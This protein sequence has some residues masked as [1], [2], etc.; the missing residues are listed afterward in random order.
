MNLQQA[1]DLRGKTALITGAGTGLGLAMATCL[2]EC[3]AHVVLC[4]R[5]ENVLRQ[6]A[7]NIGPNASLRVHDVTDTATAGKLVDAIVAERGALDILINNA[8]Q[9]LKKSSLD[10]TM[11]EFDTLLTVHLKAGF[12]LSQAAARHMGKRGDGSIVFIASMAALFGLPSTAAYTAAKSALAG[13]TR[14]LAVEW[15]PDGIR[16]NAI[17]PGWIESEMMRGAMA[18]DPQREQRI[19]SRTPLRRFGQP[20]DVGWTA[21]WLCSPAARFITGS[22]VVVDGGVSVGF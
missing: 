22:C 5:R 6:A 11:E 9:H 8:G 1:F 18:N 3:G 7:Q 19:L 16:V 13:L 10:V 20:E 21:A 4:G 17:A 15:S 12:A 2:A 14:E